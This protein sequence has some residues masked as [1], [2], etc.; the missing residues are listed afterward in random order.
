[1]PKLTIFQRFKEKR[2][3]KK[4][5]QQLDTFAVQHGLRPGLSKIQIRRE[6]LKINNE[7]QRNKALM[8]LDFIKK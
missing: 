3:Q 8:R 7:L 6:L 1:M 4:A 5:Q 2:I